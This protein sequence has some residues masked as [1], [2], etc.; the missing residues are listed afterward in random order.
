MSAI[1]ATVLYTQRSS[2]PITDTLYHVALMGYLIT[3]WIAFGIRL[4]CTMYATRLVGIDDDHDSG[5]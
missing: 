1:I 5:A 4:L 2:F 3:S